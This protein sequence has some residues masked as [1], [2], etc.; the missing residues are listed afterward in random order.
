MNEAIVQQKPEAFKYKKITVRA[1][2]FE[3][4]WYDMEENTKGEM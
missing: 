2:L 1:C 4:L 3:G